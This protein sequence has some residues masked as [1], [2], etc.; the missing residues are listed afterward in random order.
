VRRAFA[1]HTHSPTTAKRRRST[2]IVKPQMEESNQI[3]PKAMS[4]LLPAPRL[5][6]I[7][8]NVCSHCEQT[9]YFIT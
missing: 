7:K 4:P 1:R 5:G 6:V 8:Y 3:S 9:L 2:S